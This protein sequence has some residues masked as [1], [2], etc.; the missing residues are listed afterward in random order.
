M[1]FAEITAGVKLTGG[2][3]LCMVNIRG[4]FAKSGIEPRFTA[5]PYDAFGY[6]AISLRKIHLPPQKRHQYFSKGLRAEYHSPRK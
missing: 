3:E 6:H 2:S 5:Q 1:V 4:V